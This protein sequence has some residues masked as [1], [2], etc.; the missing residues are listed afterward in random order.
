M[1]QGGR[2]LSQLFKLTM[3][4]ELV[5]EPDGMSDEI[6]DACKYEQKKV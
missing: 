1:V 2:A 6:S 3:P 4:G 5:V